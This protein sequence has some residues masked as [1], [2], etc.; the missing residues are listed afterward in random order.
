MNYIQTASHMDILKL[1][2]LIAQQE[3]SRQAAEPKLLN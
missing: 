2:V 1:S 3:D